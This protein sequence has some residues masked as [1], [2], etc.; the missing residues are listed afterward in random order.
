[1]RIVIGEDRTAVEW[2]WRWEEHEDIATAL[3]THETVT[4]ACIAP[5]INPTWYTGK[6]YYIGS[7]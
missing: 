1:V 6:S 5:D 3:I 4:S 2:G 7:V